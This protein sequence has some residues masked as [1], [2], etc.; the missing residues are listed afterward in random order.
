MI[1]LDI[2]L[3]S[4]IKRKMEIAESFAQPIMMVKHLYIPMS[5][6]RPGKLVL[7]ITEVLSRIGVLT[8][9]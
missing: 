9:I 5:F 4:G 2:G 3:W 8:I 1:G 6:L 7:C